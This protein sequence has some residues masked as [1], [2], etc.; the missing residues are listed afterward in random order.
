MIFRL[1]VRET[2]SEHVSD[3]QALYTQRRPRL[4]QFTG[5][6]E[7]RLGAHL[8]TQSAMRQSAFLVIPRVLRILREGF[9]VVRQSLL[10]RA[11]GPKGLRQGDMEK[12][13]AKVPSI[14]RFQ[15]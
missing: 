11:L 4:L 1:R 8:V 14:R 12:A 2:S 9:F 15:A 13:R 10:V 3:Q 5:F 7:I 6:A